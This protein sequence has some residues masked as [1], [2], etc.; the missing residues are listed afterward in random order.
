MKKRIISFTLCAILL[1][2]AGMLLG[3]CVFGQQC[4]IERLEKSTGITLPAGTE[5]VYHF[6]GPTSFRGSAPRYTV[7]RFLEEPI[8]YIDHMSFC[9]EKDIKFE[10]D[11]DWRLSWYSEIPNKHYPDWANR[12]MLSSRFSNS[13]P[14]YRPYT[15]YF[16]DQLVLIMHTPSR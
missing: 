9:E 13:P 3:G 8:E 4:P 15:V 5:V 14:H 7:L 6:V 16:P 2:S 11:F 12:Y 1:F 10:E